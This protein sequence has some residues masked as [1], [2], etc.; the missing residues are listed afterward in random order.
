M[1]YKRSG[2][3][4]RCGDVLC[5]FGIEGKALSAC[6]GKK[7]APRNVVFCL[8]LQ[9]LVFVLSDKG[10]EGLEVVCCLCVILV[11]VIDYTKVVVQQRVRKL[12]TEFGSLRHI[13]FNHRGLVANHA[14]N[15]EQ[16]RNRGKIRLLLRKFFQHGNTF[17]VI[18]LTIGIKSLVE[19]L[20]GRLA[21]CFGTFVI[22]ENVVG[23]CQ[24]GEIPR[25]T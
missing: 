4:R 3:V 6:F 8:C 20:S 7:S 17:G 23:L 19:T 13:F 14:Y 10:K 18:T 2:F 21:Y 15:P 5:L 16:E 12:R 25:A 24:Q 1:G 9:V 11:A 22:G